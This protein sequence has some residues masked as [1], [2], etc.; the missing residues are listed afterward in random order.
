MRIKEVEL[1]LGDTR[2]IVLA[3]HGERRHYSENGENQRSLII[4]SDPVIVE[5]R[6][7]DGDP[8]AF[9]VFRSIGNDTFHG[10][11]IHSADEAKKDAF[12]LLVIVAKEIK[13]LRYQLSQATKSQRS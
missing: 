6:N 1:T 9:E 7:G 3:G 5:Y 4:H 10:E 13:E 11:F 12:E 2:V 8:V